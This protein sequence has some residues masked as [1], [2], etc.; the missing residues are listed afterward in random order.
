MKNV[1]SYYY[2]LSPQSIRRANN[3]YKF[4]IDNNNYVLY[5]CSKYIDNIK[6]IYDLS[7]ILNQNG[8][9]C[10]RIILN[11]KKN[12]FT[13]IEKDSYVLMLIYVDYDEPITLADINEFSQKT[14]NL[15]NIP[16]KYADWDNLWIQKIDYF[17]YEISQLGKR[18]TIIRD[19]FNYYVGISE[20]CIILFKEIKASVKDFK[21]ISHKRIKKE[22]TLFSLYNPFNIIIDNKTR[23]ISEYFKERFFYNNDILDEI[24][25]F[26]ST[27]NYTNI[28]L[29]LFFIRMMFPT[30]YFD[31]FEDIL[32]GKKDENELVNIINNA[33]KYEKMIQNLYFYL[34]SYINMPN[35]EWLTK[36]TY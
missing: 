10:H 14:S 18:Y 2:N 19:S 17:E 16:T 34:N 5:N 23:S 15:N 6:E 24:I 1:L 27:N 12:I 3:M 9:Y 20:V 36:K 4:S 33:T 22:D 35:I 29:L 11:N 32:F 28:E 26:L 25:Y 21:Y 7:I 13:T 31:L 30:Y 8:I